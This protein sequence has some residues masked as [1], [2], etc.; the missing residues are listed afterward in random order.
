MPN[1]DVIISLNE[2]N[3]INVIN[4]NENDLL[5][6]KKN[7]NLQSNNFTIYIC[8]IITMFMGIIMIIEEYYENSYTVSIV[9]II[10][11]VLLIILN[12]CI[13][14][15]LIINKYENQN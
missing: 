8:Y 7:N 4:I 9:S 10:L 15:L 6:Q 11:L 2:E 13:I 12:I 14:I 5:I 1:K 3:N